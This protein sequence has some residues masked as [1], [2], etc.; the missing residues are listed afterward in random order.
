MKGV[1]IMRKYVKNALY[2]A[3]DAAAPDSTKWVAGERQFFDAVSDGKN[4]K[5]ALYLAL[6]EAA[7]TKETWKAGER[8]FFNKFNRSNRINN[9]VLAIGIIA[10]LGIL[11]GVIYA[12]NRPTETVTTQQAATTTNPEQSHQQAVLDAKAS[13][14]LVTNGWPLG[15]FKIGDVDPS[16]DKSTSGNGAYNEKGARS[17]A[18]V[19]AFM[20][21]G[22]DGANKLLTMIKDND[23]HATDEQIL[24]PENWVAVQSLV[25]FTFPGN[26]YIVDGS[27]ANVGSK[28][29]HAGEIF[30][31]FINPTTD[32]ATYV[33]GACANPQLLNPKP[34]TVTITKTITEYIDRIVNV[35]V[36]QKVT[37]YVDRVVYVDK[38]KY[39]DRPVIQWKTQYIYIHDKDK[40]NGKDP[41]KDPA[42]QG[43]APVGGGQNIDPGPGTFI[44]ADQMQQPPSTT[45]VNPPAPTTSNTTESIPVGSTPDNTPA[46]A[47]ETAPTTPDAPAT[48]VVS[49]P[50]VK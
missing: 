35:P 20:K 46:P 36:I 43:N 31:M 22:S 49:V 44:P 41:S 11:F 15:T 21:N 17:P 13:K 38:V 26:T 47:P 24:N 39:V 16:I 27:I 23:I 50:G 9:G 32:K 29:G 25:G 30:L 2:A 10:L 33:R 7:P 1:D 4:Y 18:E 28:V 3:L 19:V 5:E 40:N 37:E 6:D 42:A 45:R 34:E 8:A 12:N 14:E 48:G